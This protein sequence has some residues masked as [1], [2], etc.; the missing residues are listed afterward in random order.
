[1]RS[2]EPQPTPSV[3]L[4]HEYFILIVTMDKDDRFV[5]TARFKRAPKDVKPRS[6]ERFA[7]LFESEREKPKGT[8]K[9]DPFGRP[10]GNL[11]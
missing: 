10:I 11:N 3:G 6:D 4:V 1:M 8:H 5:P 7:R 9:I 2:V